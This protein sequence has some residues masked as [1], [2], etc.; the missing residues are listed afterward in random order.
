LKF[1]RSHTKPPAPG[2]E[3]APGKD[4]VV[5]REIGER[6]A[7]DED[8]VVVAVAAIEEI[9]AFSAVQIVL[10]GKSPDPVVFIRPEQGVV[11]TGTNYRCQG[12]FH[13]AAAAWSKKGKYAQPHTNALVGPSSTKRRT[14][15]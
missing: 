10:A 4:N 6:S 1:N 7:F 13:S 3:Q 12:A 5:G 14:K 2:S 11:S 9:I 8:A 15:L